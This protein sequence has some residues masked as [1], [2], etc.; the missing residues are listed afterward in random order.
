MFTKY[1]DE[2]EEYYEM[3]LWGASL[4]YKDILKEKF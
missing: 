3:N 1:L 2:E 4:K